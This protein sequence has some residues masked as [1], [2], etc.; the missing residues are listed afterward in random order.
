MSK[1]RT[2]ATAA[3][4]ATAVRLRND[5]KS[6]QAIADELGYRGPADACKDVGRAMEN[7]ITD[8]AES[9]EIMRERELQRL[10]ELREVALGVL[11][12]RHVH[13]SGGKVVRDIEI[14][15]NDAGDLVVT[16]TTEPLEDDGPTLAELDRLVKIEES[17]RK[18]L[19]LDAPAK[20]E[21]TGSVRYV[22]EG[23]DLTALT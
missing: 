15:E 3:R 21:T 5:G 8:L 2:A 19:G 17:R 6:W 10:D 14:E 9:V 20:G 7:A 23:V 1:A 22:V 4:R 18:L 11:R 16:S 13:V 12:R